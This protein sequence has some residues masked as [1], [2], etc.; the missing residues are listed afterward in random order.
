MRIKCRVTGVIWMLIFLGGCQV[1]EKEEAGGEMLEYSIVDEKK[2][3]AEMTERIAGMEETPF[4]IMYVQGDRL[5]VG[6]GYGRQEMEG[7]AIRVDGCT[8]EKDVICVQT[9]LLG[10]GSDETEKD[11]P[12]GRG[13]HCP[14]SEYSTSERA[15][16]MEQRTCAACGKPAGDANL[17]KEC[18][19][20]WAKRLAWLLK[21]GMPAL[22]Q[23][24]YKQST[25]RERS[26]RHG[27]RR[28]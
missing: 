28:L 27:N 17:C 4:Q 20:D 24:A 23:I 2:V 25:T 7:Y 1:M 15:G 12:F 14:T 10:P 22:Q 9:T 26:P 3:P 21:A 8:E 18:V 13:S 5:Y 6:Q 16:M 11:G 19:K